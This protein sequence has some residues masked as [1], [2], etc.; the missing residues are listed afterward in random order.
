MNTGESES[1]LWWIEGSAHLTVRH[2]AQELTRENVG[3]SGLERNFWFTFLCSFIMLRVNLIFIYLLMECSVG[4]NHSWRTDT[5]ENNRCLQLIMRQCEWRWWDH[6]IHGDMRVE[7]WNSYF[8]EW[9]IF[10][11]EKWK[12]FDLLNLGKEHGFWS[13][14]DFSFSGLEPGLSLA[15]WVRPVAGRLVCLDVFVSGDSRAGRR[16]CSYQ[17]NRVPAFSPG[18]SPVTTHRWTPFSVLQSLKLW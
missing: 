15:G 8:F 2:V 18:V 10:L 9:K 13:H 6:V 11:A 14:R 5:L 17:S 4:W 12:C 7:S 3:Q 16:G 1:S